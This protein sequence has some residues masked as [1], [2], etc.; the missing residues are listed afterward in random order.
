MS[1]LNNYEPAKKTIPKADI[2]TLYNVLDSNSKIDFLKMIG[3][4]SSFSNDVSD[5]QWYSNWLTDISKVD[6]YANIII[7][8]NNY[9][10]G[11]NTNVRNQLKNVVNYII[12]KFFTTTIQDTLDGNVYDA[13]TGYKPQITIP[14][15]F[16]YTSLQELILKWAIEI[17]GIA[18]DEIK[19]YCTNLNL[20]RKAISTSRPLIQWCG[21]F[22]PD[23]DPKVATLDKQC[24]PLCVHQSSIK[25]YDN[26][27]REL[28]CNGTICVLD[29]VSINSANSF[30]NG[31]DMFQI[32]PGCELSP[33]NCKC[34]I[35]ASNDTINKVS[36]GSTG[37]SHKETFNQYCPGATCISI[38]STSQVADV[39][40]C[41][42]NAQKV[43]QKRTLGENF[44]IG[45][46]CLIL[47][48]IFFFMALKNH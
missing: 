41:D 6:V 20:T 47:F 30:G 21:C 35:D 19:S 1:I 44:W 40:T 33:D 34:I 45:V 32:C 4:D 14:G 39:Y 9:I 28:Q 10:T 38:D 37:L 29:Q 26:N 42:N 5:A 17:D 13:R 23:L 12:N 15:R 18:N 22:S 2:S 27:Y 46:T 11:D 43:S 8:L 25:L 31:A 3:V 16:N 48:M 7:I 24:D 36:A